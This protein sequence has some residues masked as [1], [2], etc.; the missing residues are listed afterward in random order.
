MINFHKF[1]LAEVDFGTVLT[2]HPLFTKMPASEINKIR[3]FSKEK[4][5]GKGAHLFEKG[6]MLDSIFFIV[7]GSVE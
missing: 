1:E 4:H 5:Y 3:T 6:I 7:S 2:E